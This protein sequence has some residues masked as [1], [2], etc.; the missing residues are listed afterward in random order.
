MNLSRRRKRALKHLRSE[1]QDVLQEQRDVLGRAGIVLNEASRQA[2]LLSDEHLAPRVQD[3]LSGARPV[4]DR[5]VWA[6]RNA[7]NNLRRVSAPVV[8]GALVSTIRALDSL[9]DDRAKQASKS[10]TSFGR[11]SGIIEKP[12]RGGAVVRTVITIAA[13]AGIGYTLYQLFRADDELW[14]A[15]DENPVSE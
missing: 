14:V 6:A 12:R 4:V 13:A 8:T 10:L 7:V 15:A 1:A 9:D 2:R 5:G 11:R 3:A